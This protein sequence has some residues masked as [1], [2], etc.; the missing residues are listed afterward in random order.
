M[1]TAALGTLENP[2]K[3]LSRKAGLNLT[4]GDLGGSSIGRCARLENFMAWRPADQGGAA[5]YEPKTSKV[6]LHRAPNRECQGRFG[7]TTPGGSYT[8]NA[9]LVGATNVTVQGSRPR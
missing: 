1:Q 3:N 2:G 6:R 8:A 9:D 4:I 7:G 5:P